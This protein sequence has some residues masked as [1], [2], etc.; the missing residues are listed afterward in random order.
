[1]SSKTTKT[2]STRKESKSTGRP[3]GP[4]PDRTLSSSINRFLHQAT[5]KQK[6]K[7]KIERETFELMGFNWSRFCCLS[8]PRPA[9]SF[10]HIENIFILLST[11]ATFPVISQLEYEESFIQRNHWEWINGKVG[12]NFTA[13]TFRNYWK[14]F[15]LQKETWRKTRKTLKL[16]F[17]CWSR[18]RTVQRIV[19]WNLRNLMNNKT[20]MRDFGTFFANSKWVEWKRMEL[21]QTLIKLKKFLIFLG[22]IEWFLN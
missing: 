3:T 1:M 12:E 17:C 15:I 21:I 19:G 14:Y 7:L 6:F 9:I 22:D 20:E 18:D 8:F 2:S 13:K 5:M 11:L 10:L 16:F 4:K